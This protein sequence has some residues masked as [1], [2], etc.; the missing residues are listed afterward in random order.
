MS[1]AYP[2]ENYEFTT[3]YQLQKASPDG[4]FN[5]ASVVL[6]DGLLLLVFRDAINNASDSQILR[7]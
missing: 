6:N 7:H 5:F 1:V 4:L 3:F 2:S